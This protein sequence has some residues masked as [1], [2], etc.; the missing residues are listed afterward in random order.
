MRAPSLFLEEAFGN[1]AH[2]SKNAEHKTVGTE[3]RTGSP[4]PRASDSPGSVLRGGGVGAP[5]GS[6][7]RRL[8]WERIGRLVELLINAIEPIARLI[9]AIS[10]L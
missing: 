9:D 2:S 10:R 7:P 5:G 1:P 8:N 3:P 4:G 6:S